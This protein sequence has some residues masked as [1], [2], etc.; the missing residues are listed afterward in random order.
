MT[1]PRRCG[2]VGEK[3]YGQRVGLGELPVPDEFVTADHLMCVGHGKDATRVDSHPIS[4]FSFIDS[5]ATGSD[6]VTTVNYHSS[7]SL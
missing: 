1:P 3:S 6:M 2:V 5:E 7:G 4:P